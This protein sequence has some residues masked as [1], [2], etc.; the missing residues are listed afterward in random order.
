MTGCLT[1]PLARRSALPQAFHSQTQPVIA[2]Y[3]AKHKLVD[4]NADRPA[5]EVEAQIASAVK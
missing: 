4:I 2:H 1:H 5:K 3:A